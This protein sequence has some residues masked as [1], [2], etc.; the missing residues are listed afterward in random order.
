M[1]SAS[2][3]AHASLTVCFLAVCCPCDS[4]A[5]VS[6]A[7]AAPETRRSV[8]ATVLAVARHQLRDLADGDYKRGTWE[9]VRASRGPQGINWVYPWGVTLLELLRSSEV[10]GDKTLSAFVIKHNEIVARHWEHLRWVDRTFGQTHPGEVEGLLQ[11]SPIRRATRITSLD[12]AGA[13]S[14]Q[15]VESFL[16]HGAKPTRE[17]TELLKVTTDWVV[18]KQARL[19]DG[20]FWRPEPNQTLWVDDLF[21]SC[22]LL[23]R[24]YQYT[25]DRRYIDD[26]ARQVIGMAARQQDKDGLFFHANFIAEHKT[27]PYKW[28]RANGWVMVATVE[29]LSVL[30]KNHPD[31]PKLLEILRKQIRGIKPL[32]AP[33]GMWRQVLDHPE[34][35]EENSCTSM[36]A[37]SIARAVRRVWISPANLTIAQ[38]AFRGITRNVT[39][40]GQVGGTSEGT[41]QI[42]RDLEYY[43]NRQRPLDDQHAP[44]PVLLA[45]T[46]LLAAERERAVMPRQ[47]VAPQGPAAGVGERS[48]P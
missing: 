40:N 7:R 25:K 2:R 42:G 11:S 6:A 14:A 13:M 12:I 24:W 29:V 20:T 48:Q 27:S 15:M 26:A 32:Q 22:S 47:P 45:G 17:E 41:P 18:N 33:S 39:E 9:E 36:F 4:L 43:A 8:R 37:F 23:T 38:K 35:W 21:M 34:L 44:G 3:L 31:R 19:P 28:G 10:T 1:R 5:E 16:R 30:P 46:E